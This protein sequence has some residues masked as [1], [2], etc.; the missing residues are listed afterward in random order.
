MDVP[1]INVF[2]CDIHVLHEF[3]FTDL[4]ILSINVCPCDVRDS[5]FI[6]S[7]SVI[8]GMNGLVPESALNGLNSLNVIG[9]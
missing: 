9:P 6:T 1:S 2:P 5:M 7:D 8:P 4:K 3:S